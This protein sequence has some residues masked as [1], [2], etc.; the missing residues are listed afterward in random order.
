MMFTGLL[1]LLVETATSPV[2]I[3]KVYIK[4][5]VS[6]KIYYSI[7]IGFNFQIQS[8]KHPENNLVISVK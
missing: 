5:V 3:A 4:V 2:L 1:K 8:A 7:T 6:S